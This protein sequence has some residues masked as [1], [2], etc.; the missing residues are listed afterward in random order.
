MSYRIVK[1]HV[2]VE[3]LY[4]PITTKVVYVPQATHTFKDVFVDERL[5]WKS[6]EFDTLEWAID[7]CK[8]RELPADEVVYPVI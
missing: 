1:R 2:L 4:K 7:Y 8:Q 6:I 5:C 3:E